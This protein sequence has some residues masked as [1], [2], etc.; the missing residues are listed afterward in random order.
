MAASPRLRRIVLHS[1]RQSTCRILLCPPITLR[2]SRWLQSGVGRRDGEAGARR[3]SCS[4]LWGRRKSRP[5]DGTR[6][7]GSSQTLAATSAVSGQVTALNIRMCIKCFTHRALKRRDGRCLA[8]EQRDE[9][10]TCECDSATT[11]IHP[12]GLV[13]SLRDIVFRL[14]TYQVR[15]ESLAPIMRSF[16][17]DNPRASNPS[18][19]SPDQSKCVGSLGRQRQSDPRNSCKFL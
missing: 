2:L 15:H 16:V 1:Q 19:A 12:Y 6:R 5:T 18:R 14:R 9:C 10:G 3:L 11:R 13:V 8:G 7:S 17:R 4:R